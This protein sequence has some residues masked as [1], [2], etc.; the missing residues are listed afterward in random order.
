MGAEDVK[1]FI[2]GEWTE[3][4]GDE[5]YKLVSPATGEHIANIPIASRADVDRAV[6][7]AHTAQ[8][9][10]KFWSP[11][12]RAEVCY[13]MA[14]AI[15]ANA[16]EIARIQTL[17]QGKPYFSESL[18]D[19]ASASANLRKAAEDVKRLSG[20]NRPS[21]DR[22]KRVFTFRRPIG[23]WAAITPFNFPI[24]TPVEYI[25]PG[26]ATGNTVIVKPPEF[27]SWAL[28]KMAEAFVDVGLPAGTISILPGAGAVGEMLTDHPGVDAI[29]F[30]G[31]TAT[32]AKILSKMGIKRSASGR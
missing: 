21:S 22:N 29:G 19:V 25:A 7:A 31:S 3:G 4:T 26:F 10:I 12:E 15:D 20:E 18:G 17:E 13:R 11:F 16:E 14:D 24:T 30:T 2:A 8:E 6:A 28:L 9:E 1:L 5:F 32:G 27:T 23:V